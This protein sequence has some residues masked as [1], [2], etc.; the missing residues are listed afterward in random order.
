MEANTWKYW[1]VCASD[2]RATNQLW[3]YPMAGAWN[4]LTIC[5]TVIMISNPCYQ[6]GFHVRLFPLHACHTTGS[7]SINHWCSAVMPSTRMVF[8]K[9]GYVLFCHIAMVHYSLVATFNC[10]IRWMNWRRQFQLLRETQHT[11]DLMRPKLGGGGAGLA[12]HV[13]R[14]VSQDSSWLRGHI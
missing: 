6:E 2:Q 4:C 14:Y 3:K 10:T 8:S 13:T 5:I 11:T 7:S 1:R 12:L 9:L